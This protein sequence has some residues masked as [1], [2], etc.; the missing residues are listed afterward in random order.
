MSYPS[1]RPSVSKIA[2]ILGSQY[3]SYISNMQVTMSPQ[4]LNPKSPTPESHEVRTYLTL[5]TFL[6]CARCNSIWILGSQI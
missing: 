5:E 3:T 4:L 6:A 1:A 2:L